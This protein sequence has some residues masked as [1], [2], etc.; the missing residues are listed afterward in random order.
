MQFQLLYYVCKRGWYS[1]SV[2]VICAILRKQAWHLYYL[3]QYAV[4]YMLQK[5]ALS[6]DVNEFDDEEDDEG[7]LSDSVSA[8]PEFDFGMASGITFPFHACVVNFKLP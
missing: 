6:F 4:G 7:E 3:T 1:G 8:H 5:V 2:L